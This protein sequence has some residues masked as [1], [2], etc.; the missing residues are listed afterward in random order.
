MT[1]TLCAIRSGR[2]L[3]VSLGDVLM[4]SWTLI[5]NKGDSLYQHLRKCVIPANDQFSDPSSKRSNTIT[6]SVCSAD[7]SSPK[8]ATISTGAVA[9]GSVSRGFYH[10]VFNEGYYTRQNTRVGTFYVFVD[11]GDDDGPD[12]GLAYSSSGE[13]N[14]DRRATSMRG[15]MAAH[16]A[17]HPAGSTPSTGAVEVYLNL[18]NPLLEL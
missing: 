16:V 2:V 12:H 8:P 15:L 6:E 14:D 7:G 11:D 17:Q 13:D 18:C 3:A 9:R 1:S 5:M 10:H 4:H